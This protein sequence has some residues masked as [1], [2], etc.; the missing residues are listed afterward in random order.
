MP[1]NFI[2]IS[3]ATPNP[4]RRTRGQVA[5][6]CQRHNATL[7]YLWF[8]GDTAYVLV[9]DGDVDQLAA[10]LQAHQVINLGDPAT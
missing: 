3:A 7:E 4:G 1:H 8:D 6:A 9:K 5:Q 10:E 2:R